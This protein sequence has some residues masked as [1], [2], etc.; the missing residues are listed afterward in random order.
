MNFYISICNSRPL[1]ARS[2]HY[3]LLTDEG[4]KGAFFGSK[5]SRRP[6][7]SIGKHMYKKPDKDSGID[8]QTSD[9][10]QKVTVKS[11]RLCFVWKRVTTAARAVPGRL[12]MILIFTCKC[13]WNLIG[14][15]CVMLINSRDLWRPPRRTGL[16]RRFIRRPRVPGW[17]MYFKI[18]EKSSFGRAPAAGR[19]ER[20]CSYW[21]YKSLHARINLLSRHK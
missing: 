17:R 8:C 14:K 19:E 4:R 15:I 20:C 11:H 12:V 7:F 16:Q 9:K 10:D 6:T 1:L 2:P 13:S 18:G 21:L 5:K 3:V